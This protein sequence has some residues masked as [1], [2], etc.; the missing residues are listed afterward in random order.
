MRT[1]QQRYRDS[2]LTIASLVLVLGFSPKPA[3]AQYRVMGLVS[4]EAGRAPWTDPNLQNPWGI[5]FSPTGPFWI[6]D[7]T[8]GLS[9]F[10]TGAGVSEGMITVPPAPGNSVGSPTGAVYNSTSSFMVTQNGQSGAA[11]FLFDTLDGTISGW[12]PGVNASEAVIAVDNS[13]SGAVY[14]GL[15]IAA[16]GANSYIYAADSWNN[17]VDIYDGNFNLV[18]Q[19]T[20]NTVPAGFTPFNV[21][22]INGQLFVTFAAISGGPG[23]YVDIFDASGNLVSRFASGGALNQPWGVA[24]AP[25]NANFGVASGA[26]LVGNNTNSGQILAFDASTGKFRGELKDVSGKTIHIPQLWALA[27][28]AGGSK[29]GPTNEL[30]FTAG[31]NNGAD[32]FFGVIIP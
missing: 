12:A 16:V 27:F 32:G 13:E 25:S 4:N 10:Y 3:A 7:N 5:A 19:F 14:T 15:A 11:I 2:A 23:G 6:S 18:G 28:G 1:W 21:Q 24:M 17:V 31:P 20:D 9:S 26:I 8:T 22:A 29:N 30:F